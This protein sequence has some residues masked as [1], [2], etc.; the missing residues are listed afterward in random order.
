MTTIANTPA[1]VF[2]LSP[3]MTC[4]D[5]LKEIHVKTAG[6]T[7]AI[8]A[9]LQAII[10]GIMSYDRICSTARA[11]SAS[12]GVPY[13]P[14]TLLQYQALIDCVAHAA[15]LAAVLAGPPPAHPSPFDEHLAEAADDLQCSR[16][17]F[18]ADT[19]Y[20]NIYTAGG[21]G[22][23]AAANIAQQGRIDRGLQNLMKDCNHQLASALCAAFGTPAMAAYHHPVNFYFVRSTTSCDTNFGRIPHA[24]VYYPYIQ[25]GG[26]DQSSVINLQLNIQT[27]RVRCVC[28]CHPG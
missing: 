28:W 14:H 19:R 6:S 26:D 24:D 9:T 11:V 3:L 5:A 18:I 4:E 8:K 10:V 20:N 15:D 22:A 13:V 21:A 23:I 12:A 27:A 7:L 16:N 2:D 1:L 25:A 17:G